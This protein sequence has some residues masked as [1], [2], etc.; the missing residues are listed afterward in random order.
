MRTAHAGPDGRDATRANLFSVNNPAVPDGEPRGEDE[1]NTVP[2]QLATIESV[3]R[4]G[5]T[6]VPFEYPLFGELDKTIAYFDFSPQALIQILHRAQELFGY[7]REDVVQHVSRELR[8]PVS[9][10]YG[11]IGFYS[12]FSKVPQG[13]HTI[14]VCTGTACYVRGAD[15]LLRGLSKLLGVDSGG[16]TPDGRYSLRCA[17]CVGACG[18]APV[19]VIDEDVHGTVK[20]DRLK[21]VVRQYK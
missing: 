18:I 17:R 9:K 15:R 7:L 20:T 2:S 21:T 12:F 11:V 4:S 10:I 8:I 13:K 1:V 19:M 6:R 16:T 14:T 3:S 5:A